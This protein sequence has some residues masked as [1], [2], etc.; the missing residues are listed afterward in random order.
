MQQSEHTL[1]TQLEELIVQ[2]AVPEKRGVA[3]TPETAL[4]DEVGIDSPRM[5]DLMLDIEDRFG[6]TIEDEQM[7]QVRTF[8][9][10]VE[11]RLD[12]R[13]RARERAL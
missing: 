3:I 9:D 1:S 6:I 5:I 8:A 4:V 7:Q 12:V 10:L 13:S 2:F 11:P